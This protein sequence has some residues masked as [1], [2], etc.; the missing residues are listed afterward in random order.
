MMEAL[1]Q[2]FEERSAEINSYLELLQ[3]IEDEAR[4]GPPR[5]GEAGTVITT[6][7]QRILYSCVYLQL[8]NLV[9][10]TIVRCL[11]GVTD[12]ALSSGAWLPG[13]LSHE[14]RREWVRTTARTHIELN[15]EN[16]LRHALDLCAHLVDALPVS[17][18]KFEK[19]GGSW[20]DDEIEAIADRLGFDLRLSVATRSNIKRP[21]RDDLGALRLV[22]KL[23]NKLAHGSISFVECGENHSVSELRD[24]T[25]KT[26]AYL[27]EVVAAFDNFIVTHAFLIPA[28]RPADAPA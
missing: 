7:Q 11:E 28:R 23:R 2:A 19:S 12:S 9:E 10:A 5:I 17:G 24:L 13:D 8:Y 26:A 18:F 6:Q 16:R 20:D 14:L 27:R 21:F 3:G 25:T 22:K 4:N 1:G 15:H